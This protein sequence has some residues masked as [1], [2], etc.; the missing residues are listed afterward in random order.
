MDHQFLT[1]QWADLFALREPGAGSTEALERVCRRYWLP[2]YGYVRQQNRSPEDAADATQA[3]FV[4]LLAQ[5]E[6]REL[7]PARGRFRNWLLLS[8]R[9]FLVDDW[10][11]SSALS[12][13]PIA[14]FT[15]LDIEASEARILA[16]MVPTESPED[17][18]HRRWAITLVEGALEELEAEC[19]R[20]G[21]GEI[22]VH[23][24]QHLWGDADRVSHAEAA[25]RFSK[26]EGSLKNQLT[27]L[28]RRFRTLLR[29]RVAETVT[30]ESDVDAEL[31]SLLTLVRR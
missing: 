24:S 11:A 2:A 4:K 25:L 29:N 18:Y 3:F 1:T 23:L 20:A 27:S 13:R 6:L 12:R 26:D 9:R 22:F 15:S 30:H 31:R 28:R 19:Q 10:R 8:L 17:A 7:D 16:E 21:Q 14:G 5:P